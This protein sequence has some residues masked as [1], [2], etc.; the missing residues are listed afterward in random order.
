MV[1]Y[2]VSI[3]FVIITVLL[4]VGS[5]NLTDIVMKRRR[6]TA[7]GHG[8]PSAAVP[9]VRDLL[10]LGAGRDEPPP[11][12]LPEAESELVGGYHVEYSSMSF[13]LFFLGEYEHDPD[14]RDDDDPVPRRLAAA[15]STSRPSTGCRADLVRAQD[16]LLLFVFAWVRATLPRYRYDQ[17]MR[18]GWKVFLPLSLF[19]VVATARRPCLFDCKLPQ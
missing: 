3:G 1:S 13:A 18:L 7:A 10:H 2:E 19:W 14:V 16:L 9:D 12:D 11:F 5:L 15:D 6:A 17:L 8:S 4:C